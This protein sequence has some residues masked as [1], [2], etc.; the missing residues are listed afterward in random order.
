M[1]NRLK[2][3]NRIKQLSKLSFWQSR[4]RWLKAKFE[5]NKRIYSAREFVYDRQGDVN[6]LTVLVQSTFFSFLFSLIFLIMLLLLPFPE[7]QNNYIDNY[8]NFLIA[9]ASITGIF[10][11]LYFTGLNTVIGGLYAKSPKPVRELLIQERVN[12]FSVRFLVFL[13]LLCLELLA[14]GILFESRPIS[15]VF[16]IALFGC[17]AVLFFAELGKRAFYFFDPSLFANQLQSEIIKWAASST[18]KGYEFNNPSF[19][20]HYRKKAENAIAGF[21]GLIDL[22]KTESHL[23]E[24]LGEV[25]TEIQRTYIRYLWAKQS[26]PTKSRWFLYSPKFQDWFMASEHMVRIASITQTD[27]QPQNEP[28]H[29][30][31]EEKLENLE[32]MILSYAIEQHQWETSQ[33]V[34]GKIFHQFT[35]LGETGE[36]DRAFIFLQKIQ[37]VVDKFLAE[38][39]AK[40]SSWHGEEMRLKIGSIQVLDSSLITMTVGLFN[41]LEKFNLEEYKK[42]VSKQN[43]NKPDSPYG[44]DL[45]FRL[46]KRVEYI[47]DS[48]GFERDV[49]GK[50]ITPSWYINELI[51]QEFSFYLK[52]VSEKI[53]GD[54]INFIDKILKSYED[55]KRFVECTIVAS[56]AQE[57]EAKS[58]HLLFVVKKI[59]EKLEEERSIKNLPW[60]EWKW[61]TYEERLNSFHERI[62]VAQV[63]HLGKLF[64][65]NRPSDFPDYF[66]K[67]V[68]LAGE[69][70][71]KSLRSNNLDYFAKLFPKYLGGILLTFEKMRVNSQNLRPE[72]FLLLLAEPIMD[73]LDI[74]GYSLIYSEYHQNQALWEPCKIAW[75]DLVKDRGKEYLELL[76]LLI[77]NKKYSFGMTNRD[78]SRS[79][80]EIDF[81]SSMR[82]LPRKYEKLSGIVA[83][84][85]LSFVDHPSELIREL[86][87][88]DDHYS[89][90]HD[91]DEIFIDIFLSTLPEAK[92]LDFGIRHKITESISRKKN[93]RKKGSK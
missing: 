25:T 53:L 4:S 2:F 12:H 84:I 48:I 17:F 22:A 68:V 6:I 26:I 16:T 33:N 15:S 1:A 55:Q 13:T 67:G 46:L 83:P 60:A 93:R 57:M 44:F 34:L 74:S 89:S 32:I 66:G 54:G 8:D 7:I 73:L 65:W 29:E 92:D 77:K 87:G 81:N 69:E 86:G 30:W 59:S 49:E 45:P 21:Q 78:I 56:D 20:D 31:L 23:K 36:I 82:L 75:T 39:I 76:A 71:L 64:T 51:L 37:E 72:Q 18:P 9:V 50:M 90:F 5:Y 35:V 63:S 70:C 47:H 42:S 61:D 27:L 11:S 40:P 19:Q 80:W 79:Q 91:S 52:E 3:Q 38:P 24:T 62:V 43:W 88:A 14:L 10:L 58:R 85:G 41:V 28:D